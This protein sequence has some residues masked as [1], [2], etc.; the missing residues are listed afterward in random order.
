MKRDYRRGLEDLPLESVRALLAALNRLP[1]TRKVERHRA[2]VTQEMH[3]RGLGNIQTSP[4]P[5]VKKGRS[6]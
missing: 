1:W 3:R 6:P 2:L 4:A 5:T